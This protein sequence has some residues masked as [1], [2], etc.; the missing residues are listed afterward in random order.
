MDLNLK[1]KVAIVTGAACGIGR[2]AALKLASEGAFVIIDDIDL[3]TARMVETEIR[4]SGGYAVALQADV[5]RLDEINLLVGKV[6]NLFGRIDILVNNAGI[7]YINGQN[8]EHRSFEKADEDYWNGEIGITLFGVLN[9]CKAVLD[10]MLKQK[11]G[12]I[13]N[14]ASDSALSPRGSKTTVY[15][16]GKG[17]IITF[18]RN[19]AF[20]LGP[21]GIRVNCISPGLIKTSQRA[22]AILSGKEKRSGVLDFWKDAQAL[23]DLSPVRRIGVPLEIANVVAFLASEDVSGYITGQTIS[24]N[25]GT[26]MP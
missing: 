10:T 5:T 25:G 13:I 18:T 20:E 15:G 12:S 4:I 3:E 8:I 19:L 16:A 17:S 26:F 22:E 7:W 6:L 23:I 2:A 1:N 14:I 21:Q 9:C 24:V 11:S